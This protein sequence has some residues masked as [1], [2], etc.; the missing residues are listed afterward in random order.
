M[1]A[2][3]RQTTTRIVFSI[4]SKCCLLYVM[5]HSSRVGR[6]RLVQHGCMQAR[7]VKY[8]SSYA[9]AW[10]NSGHASTGA[11]DPFTIREG[12]SLFIFLIQIS[13]IPIFFLSLSL[14]L[15]SSLP[16]PSLLLRLWLGRRK[17]WMRYI[18]KLSH[19]AKLKAAKAS[20]SFPKL[21][22]PGVS[23]PG[24]ASLNLTLT[25]TLDSNTN[26][27][28]YNINPNLR[29]VTPNPFKKCRIRNVRLRKC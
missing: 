17:H 29:Y 4:L 13:S 9:A 15:H 18:S 22:V 10:K 20:I 1:L 2:K 6:G 14:P 23:Y 19:L 16:V 7:W 24:V 5:L 28:S 11:C 25:L 26:P 3:R 27:S 12:K 21:F 8:L